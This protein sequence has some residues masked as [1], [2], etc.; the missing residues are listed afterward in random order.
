MNAVLLLMG[1]LALSYLGSSLVSGRSARGAGLVSGIEYVALGFVLGPRVLDV[2][3]I[4]TLASFEPAVEVALGWLAFA[5]GLS[6]GFAG[7]R[8]VRAAS[9]VLGTLASLLTGVGAAVATWFA[10]RRFDSGIEGIQVWLLAGGVGAVCSETSRHAVRRVADRQG[11]ARGPVGDRLDELGHAGDLLP[12]LAVAVLFA[13]Q[14]APGI[15]APAALA[16]WPAIT[17]GLALLLGAGA[18]LLLSGELVLE[19]AWGLLFGVA[20]IGIGVSARLALSTLT[21]SFFIGLAL[22]VLSRHRQE[23]RAMVAPTAWPVL[24]PALLLAGARLDFRASSALPWIAAAAIGARVAAKVVVGWIL[25]ATWPPMR[26][27]G[28]FLGLSLL[29]S[30]ALS[31]SIGL[32]FALRFPGKIGDT[33]LAVAVLSA[34]VGEFVG[35]ARLRNALALAGEMSREPSGAG[36]AATGAGASTAGGRLGDAT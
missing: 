30:G 11:A 2:V 16:D 7:P 4:D 33:V 24:L 28:V 1:L 35:P 27:A 31:M 17:V 23:L 20:L 19:N 34:A 26:K 14:P 8:R 5:F 32:T 9:F 12:L 36:A 18:A 10:A 25:V 3:G 15:A 6:F 21:A 13:L 29:S 22:S